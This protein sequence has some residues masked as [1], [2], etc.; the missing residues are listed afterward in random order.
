MNNA[1]NTAK[2]KML[3]GKY[4]FVVL[5]DN[6]EY[7]SYER[8]V[9]PL[10]SLLQTERS[11]VGAVAADKCIGAGAAHLY[12]LLGISEVWANIISM[13]AIRILQNKG[14]NVFFEQSVPNII[15]RR[16]DGI[17]PIEEAVCAVEDSQEAYGLILDTLKN[18][19]QKTK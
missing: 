3:D 14:I 11:F 15:N 4:T 7:T 1:L 13:S 17:C 16:G 8:G 2:Q 12:V 5:I 19:Q 6:D 9:K 10:L 18:L